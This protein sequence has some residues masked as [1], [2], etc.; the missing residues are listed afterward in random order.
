MHI[1]FTD[2]AVYE[3]NHSIQEKPAFMK[4]VFDSEGCGCAVNGV[5]AI[6]LVSRSREY[7]MELEGEP[8]PVIVDRKHEVYFEE[9]M[10]IDYLPGSHRYVL[11]S[12]NQIYN[13]N[14]NIIDKR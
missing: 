6:W 9:E 7:D 5:P 1:T 12:D 4:L 13:A 2:T 14:L 10:V 3:I 8:F 11:K